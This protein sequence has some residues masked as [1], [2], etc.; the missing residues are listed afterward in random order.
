VYVLSYTN[1]LQQSEQNS[2]I[3]QHR[4]HMAIT[5]EHILPERSAF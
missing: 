1:E 2:P 3:H 4:G 5:N